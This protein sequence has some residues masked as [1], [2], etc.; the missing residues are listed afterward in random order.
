VGWWLNPNHWGQGVV[1]SAVKHVI[2]QA[3]R[4]PDVTRVFAP[5][6]AGN[7]RSVRV[8]EKVGLK[9]ESLQPRSAFK[10]G[11]VIDRLLY[12]TYR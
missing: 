6:H 4:L 10:R 1:P 5:V 2:E 12:A 7:A 8:A 9:L 11:Q 3:F